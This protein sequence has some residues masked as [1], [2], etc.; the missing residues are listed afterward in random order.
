MRPEP[1][2]DGTT[3]PF[4]GVHTTSV[5]VETIAVRVAPSALD[6]APLVTKAVLVDQTAARAGVHGHGV[7][8]IEVDTFN[9][10]NFSAVGPFSSLEV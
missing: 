1:N 7:L 4:H 6:A 10:V 2:L 8:V 5:V 3:A 9:N